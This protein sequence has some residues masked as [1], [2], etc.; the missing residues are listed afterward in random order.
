LNSLIFF[1]FRWYLMIF[2][3]MSSVHCEECYFL[4]ASVSQ[5]VHFVVTFLFIK[6][7]FNIKKI[8]FNYHKCTKPKFCNKWSIQFSC[9]KLKGIYV[10][11]CMALLRNFGGWFSVPSFSVI[12]VNYNFWLSVFHSTIV[13][14]LIIYDHVFELTC[15]IY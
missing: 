8:Y 5:K 15:K 2:T 10:Q 4:F 7:F 12:L 6:H 13:L 11:Q 1:F 14:F 9:L 3:Y